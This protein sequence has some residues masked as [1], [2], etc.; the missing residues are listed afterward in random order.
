[1]LDEMDLLSRMKDAAPL[2]AG[3]FEE[4]RTTLRAAMADNAHQE[5]EPRQGGRPGKLT[6]GTRGKVGLG[7][8]AVT[9]AAAAAVVLG[10]TSSPAPQHPAASGGTT[11]PAV[12]TVN[13]HLAQLADYIEVHENKL[14]GDATL[15][16][17]NQSASNATPGG[18]GVDLLADSG[19]YYWA[20][21]ES[22]LPQAI[23]DH[24][25][26]SQGEREVAAALYA[27][28]GNITTARREVGDRQLRAGRQAQVD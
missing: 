25:D 11:K 27:V 28:N 9:A 23:A 12:P 16:I 26:S 4:A 5:T 1:M 22:G 17:R 15:E 18:N 6:W 7:I 24:E 3:A 19:D 21:T 13:P 20:L 10:V 14:P 8:T 2:R